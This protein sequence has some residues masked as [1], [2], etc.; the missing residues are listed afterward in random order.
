M[1]AA[2]DASDAVIKIEEADAL[3][4]WACS[5][6]RVPLR[7]P[8]WRVT[9]TWPWEEEPRTR[10]SMASPCCSIEHAQVQGTVWLVEGSR[11]IEAG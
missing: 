9:I 2:D 11:G 4:H 8:C 1:G 3:G 10:T 7:G 5:V 6:C